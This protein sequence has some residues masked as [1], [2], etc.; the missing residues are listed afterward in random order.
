MSS[1]NGPTAFFSGLSSG[2]DWRAMVDQLMAVDHRGVDLLSARKSQYDQR[3][4]AWQEIRTKLLGL[5]TASEALRSRDGLGLFSARLYGNGPTAPERLVSASVGAG[6]S[7]ATHTIRV[8]QRAQAQKLS[9]AAFGSDA[10]ALGLSGTFLVN[11]QAVSVEAS[12]CLAALGRKINSL[13][14]GQ[15]PTGVSASV[16]RYGET[17]YRLLL[18]STR[19]GAMGMSLRN[20]GTTDV[21]SVVGWTDGS[22]SLRDPLQGGARS[23]ALAT[24]SV[25]VGAALGL[26]Q[27][28]NGTVLIDGVAVS[29]DLAADSLTDIRDKIN[30]AGKEA[31]ILTETSGGETRYRLF[32]EGLDFTDEN[33][34]LETLGVVARGHGDLMGTV[35]S[36]ANTRGGV[37]VTADTRIR[38]LDGYMDY[39][40]GDTVTISGTDHG[41]SVVG[42][43]TLILG[44]ETTV[45]DLLAQIE[46][47][48]G[49]V[50]A[51]VTRDGRI[52][53][54][55]LQA[56]S[57]LLS[58][59]LTP[60][61][62]RVSFGTFD[63][64][65][66]LRK[67]EVQ[68]GLD[69][70]VE[71]DGVAVT[72]SSNRIEDLIEGVTLDLLGQDSAST[73]TLQVARDVEGVRGK[74]QAF[75]DAY[76]EVM[77]WIAKQFTYDAQSAKGGGPLF[78]DSTLRIIR[79]RI[80]SL[81][82]NPVWG[83]PEGMGTLAMAGIRLNAQNRLT[84]N[85]TVLDECLRTRF[86]DVEGL[87]SARGTAE[88]GLLAYLGHTRATRAGSYA[89]EITHAA[90]Q[91]ALT[92][93]ADLAGGLPQGEELRITDSATGR[94]AS[95]S[96][97]AGWGLETILSAIN[98][99]LAS[100]RSQELQGANATGLSA[101]TSWAQVAGA[102]DGDVITFSGTDHGGR[103]VQGSYQVSADQTLASLLGVIE[104]AYGNGVTASL[105]ASG[106]LIV[107]DRT[108]GDSQ[109][110][111]SVDSAAVPGLDLGAM[112]VA[113]E[114]RYALPITAM[115]E[116]NRLK[117]VH[118]V[119]GGAQGITAV[120]IGGTALGMGDA[121]TETGG[122]DVAGT[123]NGVAAT[124]KGR[125][126]SLEQEGDSAS[127]LRLRYDGSSPTSTR[128]TLTI[129]VAEGFW[130]ELDALTDPVGGTIYHRTGA[131]E[132]T[133]ADIK[134]DM[135]DMEGRLE[136]R[137]QRLIRQFT[138]MEKTL[139]ALQ[140]QMSWLTG[141]INS[142]SQG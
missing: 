38:D 51:S 46:A 108:A 98:S 66:A 83:A 58:L 40:A 48:L 142:L 30:A 54:E 8:L 49:S 87:L 59:E 97:E 119:Y 74:V 115:A 103:A 95:V 70:R 76:N 36:A 100:N 71:V 102:E 86:S 118:Q 123:I 32:I 81:V 35:G 138:A 106:R 25:A 105:D 90:R 34:V 120:E 91:A 93:G 45:G 61:S 89:V 10:S 99:E 82:I 129:G 132:R 21:L 4:S 15:T 65:A 39:G 109:L 135:A 29:V 9:S 19:E 125:I 141:Q 131:L 112:A 111:L 117:L 41:G 37:A 67:R 62:A 17:D 26:A 126:L 22:V 79:S 110:S 130:R 2:I 53:V 127:G 5:R 43:A 3:L 14:A 69:A 121:A 47:T 96:L 137:R 42:P 140:A 57:S 33:N 63:P 56:G 60:S 116:G 27:A 20:A 28:Q 23:E 55:D 139:S 88:D 6:A 68:A 16:V 85:S 114:G 94:Q 128:F 78:A 104:Q 84:V 75:V 107:T 24:A 122:L 101:S 136:V 44:D 7:E 13:N 52:Q 1:V 73:V 72:R 31:A 77:D 11:G 113:S 134:G 12:D 50:R 18:T 124:G 80:Q 64:P 92:G 133:I